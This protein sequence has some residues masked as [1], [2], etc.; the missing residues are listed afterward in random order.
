MM[1]E[2]IVTEQRNPKTIHIDQ[3]STVDML[4]MLNEED[5]LVA[6]AVEAEIPQIARAVELIADAMKLGGRL[7]YLGAG[8]SGRI[9]VLDASEVS[10]AFG[11]EEGKIYAFIA[12]GTEA[13]TKSVSGAQDDKAMGVEEL[14]NI[15]VNDQD[16][17]VGITSSGSTPYVTGSLEYA[18]RQGASTIALTCMHSSEC[19]QIADLI[20]SP[21]VGPEAI[22]GSTRLK[23]ATA[24][25]MI[26]NMIST[27]VMIKLGKVFE[28]LMIDLRPAN[29][30]LLRRRNQVVALALE[31]DDQRAEELLT[32]SGGN[33]RAAILMGLSNLSLSQA[34]RLLEEH[35]ND[36]RACMCDENF[37]QDLQEDSQHPLFE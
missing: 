2:H 4:H 13:L 20:I 3:V 14:K 19:A 6:G 29:S 32:L 12:G 9:G 31:V 34:L 36:L 18:K 24:N 35:E 27:G 11:L 22:A 37:R 33:P 26:L 23:S 16:V 1:D 25:K 10:S 17:V 5:K 30:K 21:A 28:N 8:T 15:N 7:I